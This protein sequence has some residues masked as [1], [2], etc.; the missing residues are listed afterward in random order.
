MRLEEPARA[1]PVKSVSLEGCIEEP[2]HTANNKWIGTFG[3]VTG[4]WRNEKRSSQALFA[5]IVRHFLIERPGAQVP[6]LMRLEIVQFDDALLIVEFVEE[7]YPDGTHSS[8]HC[9][10]IDRF[11][12]HPDR[13]DVT[14]G[15]PGIEN[16]CGPVRMG[17]KSDPGIVAGEQ[18]LHY[19]DGFPQIL[20]LV[21]CFFPFVTVLPRRKRYHTGHVAGLRYTPSIIAKHPAGG[22]AAGKEKDDRRGPFR[23]PFCPRLLVIEIESDE[24]LR[25][26]LIGDT[27]SL[28]RTQRERVER[29]K[30][31]KKY[32]DSPGNQF[33]AR[34]Q[35]SFVRIRDD[36]VKER[37]RA[38]GD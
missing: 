35:G 1:G 16:G 14:V 38:W 18:F 11:A 5:G 26:G 20:S 24:R 10:N 32:C 19:R 36:V 8:R 12:D 30:E 17:Q 13:G 27:M 7:T 25:K 4:K 37:V 34:L 33:E 29:K 31:Q 2:G 15:E 28:D 6:S 3:E 21:R 22:A 23:I 9:R